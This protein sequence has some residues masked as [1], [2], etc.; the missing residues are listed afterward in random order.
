[1]LRINNVQVLCFNDLRQQVVSYWNKHDHEQREDHLHVRQRI[2]PKSTQDDELYYLQACEVMHL[3]LWHS[4]DVVSGGIRRL[5]F[6]QKG[7]SITHLV[8]VNRCKSDV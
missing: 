1:M 6:K 2:H 8:S 4:A 7:H 5:F 3:S